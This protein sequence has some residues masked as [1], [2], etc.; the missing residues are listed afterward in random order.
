MNVHFIFFCIQWS[1]LGSHLPSETRGL[2]STKLN[3]TPEPWNSRLTANKTHVLH[4]ASMR[5][6]WLSDGL[7][8]L[9]VC[10]DPLPLAP[11]SSSFIDR[12]FILNELAHLAFHARGEVGTTAMK[13]SI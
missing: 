5:Y 6:S 3:V 7:T 12:L 2:D 13:E 10:K 4:L 9:R 1:V 8:H 11:T